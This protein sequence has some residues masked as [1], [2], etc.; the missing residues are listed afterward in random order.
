MIF[1][2]LHGPHI[3]LEGLGSVIGF[4][5]EFFPEQAPTQI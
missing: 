2:A 3:V 4:S 1:K 5:E